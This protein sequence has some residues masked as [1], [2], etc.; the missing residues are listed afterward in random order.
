[1]HPEPVV[2][3]LIGEL[4]TKANKGLPSPQLDKHG[5]RHISYIRCPAAV[6]SVQRSRPLVMA[7]D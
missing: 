3:G 1:M 2:G 7:G 6:L 5:Y 4:K